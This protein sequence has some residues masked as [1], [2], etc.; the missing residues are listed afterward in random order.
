M[1]DSE[2][3]VDRE[4]IGLIGKSALVVVVACACTLVPVFAANVLSPW[5]GVPVAVGSFWVW[6]RLG[7]P[8]SPGFL[9]GV[10]CLWGYAAILGSM[11][12]CI[13]RAVR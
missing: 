11:I 8:P 1:N 2:Q 13:A 7:P 3:S 10:L 5:A 6:S 12:A 4:V 9:N